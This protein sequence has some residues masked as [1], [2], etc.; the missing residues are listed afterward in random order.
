MSSFNVFGIPPAGLLADR[1]AA[2]AVGV[3]A[4]YSAT[5]EGV[6][7]RSNGTTW[8]TW[9]SGVAPIAHIHP[10]SDITGLVTDLST[11]TTGLAT[12]VTN[13]TNADSAL[14]SRIDALEL[15]PPTHTHP[16]SDI[17][18]LVSD[19]ATLTTGLST[20][21]TNR[22]NAD[23][24]LDT[25]IDALELAPPA[26]THPESDIVDLVADLNDIDSR[27]DDLEAIAPAPEAQG[28]WLVSGGSVVFLQN[29]DF[30]ISAAV[31]YINGVRYTSPQTDLSLDAAD[32]TFDRFDAIVVTTS[33]T[34]IK[35]TGTAAANPALPD[36]DPETE[37]ALTYVLVQAASSNPGITITNIYLENTEWTS[38]V[39][40]NF[41]AA[42]LVNPFAG[43]KDIEATTAAAG[44]F[45]RL[46]N[47]AAITLSDKKQVIF[48]IRSKATWANPKT[49]QITWYNAGVKKG[50]SVA[51]GNGK[52]G[53]DSSVTSGYQQIAIPISAFGVSALDT[54][55]RLEFLVAGGG[56]TIGFYLDN[57]TL[58]SG[59]SNTSQPS[60]GAATATTLGLIRT[61]L[62]DANPVT[63][64]KRSVDA[65]LAL[66]AA[67]VHTH[68]E[69][70]IT[71][72]V[73]DLL[74]FDSR[75]DALETS[76]APPLTH[77]T[78]HENGG[79]DEI[80]VAGLS[81]ALAD[82]QPTS[83]A[84]MSDVSAFI[85]TMLDDADAAA[86]RATLGLGTAAVVALDTDTTL[87]ANSDTRTPSQ[88]AIKTYVDN[89][90]A[91][92]PEVL[93]IACS[94]ESTAITTGTAKVTFRMP[95]AMTLSAARASVTTAP[96]G[97]TIIIDIKESGTTI[98]STK[99]SIDASEKTSTTAASAAVIS[100]TSLADDAEMTINFDQVGSTIAGTG[101]KV[102][103]IGTR[104]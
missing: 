52:Y 72:L 23:S 19:L 96:T 54:I 86:A 89:A 11:L 33:G 46:T 27:L 53:F 3:G 18:G 91:K 5:D 50:Q 48:N 37:M 9:L 101:V 49:L 35:V 87:A 78:T 84:Q 73:A 47:G 41:N 88:K 14:D 20:E 40:A 95:F 62:T 76:G 7:Y 45:V 57:I 85:K 100:D 63:Y 34:V 71:G 44:N 10:E 68:A 43:T 66:K 17:T 8:D 39:S 61:D 15:S 102:T 92:Q 12:E 31:Y 83:I 58:E 26:H 42:S 81:G 16:E 24:A 36:I 21:V 80:N 69:S 99:L 67:L 59:S 97:S 74:A 64:L 60:I 82:T 79:G 28:T 55:D 22:T 25:R 6:L 30:R 90:V 2:T 29:Y 103:L 94:D 98:F 1:P 104:T 75:L 70:D 56:G 38:S 51:F 4:L 93:Q 13:R 77:H 65:L 32:G